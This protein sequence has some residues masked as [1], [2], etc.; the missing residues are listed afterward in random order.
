MTNAAERGPVAAVQTSRFAPIFRSLKHRNYRLYLAGLMVSLAGTYVQQVAEGWLIYELTDSA[1]AL[2]YVSFVVMLPMVPWAVVAGALA[3]R[4]PKRK[5]LALV[6]AGQIVPPLALAALVWSGHV[7]VWHVIVVNLIMGLMSTIDQPTR[8]ALLAEVVGPADL[9][10]ALAL[11]STGFNIARVLG[12]AVAGVLIATVGLAGAFVV[13]GLSFVAVLLALMV[14]QIPFPPKPRQKRS[15][16]NDMGDGGRYLLKDRTISVFI[17]LLVIISVFILPYQT[18]LPVFARDILQAGP[19]GLGF[20]NAA[21]GAGAIVGA[22]AIAG[23]SGQQRNLVIGSLMVMTPIVCMGFAFANHLVLACLLLALV[24]SGVVALKT[25]GFTVIQVSTPDELRGRITSLLLLMMGAAPR[26]GG[27]IWGYVASRAGAPQ[28][29]L[30]SALLCLV[31]GTVVVGL[32]LPK[33]Q[34]T[35]R[36]VEDPSTAT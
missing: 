9:D 12:P 20:L 36:T 1:F 14:M 26:A 30:A 25:L 10:N 6:Q 18:L 15:L 28:A 31:T 22:L 29:L 4:M 3:D 16:G 7:Q 34:H 24:S 33:T 11:T 2:G 19:T 32:F 21:A 8:Q 35:K 13:N 27:L 5:L 23:L 17:L